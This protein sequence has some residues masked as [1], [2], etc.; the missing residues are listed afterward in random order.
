MRI[1]LFGGTT[2]GRV[3]A[4]ELATRGH[5]VCV[6]VAT[7]MGAEQLHAMP[8]MTVRVGRLD[9][10]AIGCL[11]RGFD[12]CVDA[13]H[14]Y[15]LAATEAIAEGCEAAGVSVMRVARETSAAVDPTTCVVVDSTGAAARMLTPTE[16]PVLLT[17]GSKELG[18]FGSLD[19]SRLYARV[20]PTHEGLAACERI[21]IPHRNVIAMQGPFKR[22]LN[23]AIMRHFGIRW[24]VTKDGGDVGG[25]DDKLAAA[26]ACDVRCVLIRR[27][28]EGGVSVERL[29]DRVGR[30]EP[31][32]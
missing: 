32:E 18:A 10:S 24:L 14:P 21:G 13:T 16:G 23:E 26:R 27:P 31:C 28:Q 1:L 11:A 15:A 2:E 30:V 3:L 25:L 7:P 19:P 12:L 4:D 17:T 6:S 29:L 8:R 20:L 5:D 9:A 22:D